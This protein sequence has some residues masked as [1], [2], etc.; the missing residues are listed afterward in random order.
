M[1]ENLD[2]SSLKKMRIGLVI[3]GH[4]DSRTGGF[5]YDSRLV[6][7]L[8]AH[9]DEVEI[10]S[11][12]WLPYPLRLL[13]NE[14]GGFLEKMISGNYDVIL[15][16]EMNHPS[17][18]AMNYRFKQR[19]QVPVVSIVH[20]L[21]VSEKTTIFQ[22]DLLKIFEKRYLE[23]IDRF[24]FN[25]QTTQKEVTQLLNSEPIG[26]V[27]YPGKDLLNGGMDQEEIEY[28]CLRLHP[29]RIVF[30]GNLI[31]RK[32]L[33]LAI[34]ALVQ[35]KDLAWTF[36]IIGDLH[37]D[38]QHTR[39]LKNLVMDLGLEDRIFFRGR[40]EPAQLFEQ[41]RKSQ[42]LLSPAQY[43]GFGITFVEAMGCGLPVISLKVGAAPEVIADG[44]TGILVPPDDVD[45]LSS[46]IRRLLENEE[47]FV[48]MS[49]AA[50]K[51]FD[52]FPTWS[53]SMNSIRD[54]LLGVVNS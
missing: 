34:K 52:Q 31:T 22:R 16:D 42:I 23:T 39:Y 10:L 13:H 3:Y 37:A 15:Q 47:L 21:K 14:D 11:Q 5:L 50:R 32:G 38:M 7:T 18:F 25:S 9:G 48:K 35:V 12:P 17:L 43:E 36:E 24:I 8:T 20:H 26:M 2:Y 28:R 30:A 6:E 46:A 45:S 54:F 49:L 1:D 27:A 19:S 33:A 44:E 40:M 4:L 51:R 41:F 53:E 29:V